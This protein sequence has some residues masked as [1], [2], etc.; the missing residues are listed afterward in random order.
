MPPRIPLLPSS[1]HLSKSILPH[2]HP[3]LRHAS[4]RLF[5][6]TLHPLHPRK[7]AQD[8]DSMNV[9]ANEYSKSGTDDQAARQESASFDPK[10]TDPDEQLK[11]AG[12]E[13]GAS[14]SP[15]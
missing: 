13:A 7:D 6:Q 14:A 1:H 5:T 11:T 9:E 3:N 2:P 10:K 4:L 8:K 12:D 15:K